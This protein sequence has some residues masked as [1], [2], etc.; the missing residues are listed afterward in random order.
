MD[1]IL[2]KLDKYVLYFL[3]YTLVFVLFFNTLSYTLP[4]VLAFIFAYFLQKPTK[5]L[6]NKFKLKNSI[7]SLITTLLFFALI[8]FL[9]SMGI[10]TITS[11]VIALAKNTQV[12]I[13]KNSGNIYKFFNDLQNNFNDLDPSIIKAVQDY[14]LNSL[15]KIG[16]VT[17]N[18][19]GKVISYIITF[20]TTI[21]YV[22]MVILFTLLATY[23]FTKDLSSVKNKFFS[24][25]SKN[26]SLRLSFIFSESRKMLINYI[27]S[28]A[29]ILFIT[30]SESLI[31]FLFFKVKYAVLL[32]LV[33]AF[34]DILPVLGIGATYFPLALYYYFSHNYFTAV[35][36]LIMY[37]IVFLVRQIIEPRIVSSSLGV[38]PVAILAAIFIGLKAN[39]FAGMFYCVFLVVFFIIFKKVDVL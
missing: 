9:L 38:H 16:S 8:I 37:L 22:V 30:F 19:T 10:A 21:P 26:R 25:F 18:L 36:I 2:Q 33:A 5:F 20:V 14:F 24:S 39:G 29:L 17:F 11:E 35:G 3:I 1:E 23:F 12:Y 15:S 4:F 32:S 31:G 27:F 28:Y 7:A 6:I 34:V 13:L